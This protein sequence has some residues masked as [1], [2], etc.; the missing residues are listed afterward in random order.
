MKKST[1][2]RKHSA[3]TSKSKHLQR[4]RRN[5]VPNAPMKDSP[6]KG[7][8]KRQSGRK[9]VG[10]TRPLSQRMLDM[11]RANITLAVGNLA[12]NQA[13]I[14]LLTLT[15]GHEAMF[16]LRD[17][18]WVRFSGLNLSARLGFEMLMKQENVRDLLKLR[19][20]E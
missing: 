3:G 19:F 5:K 15:R 8:I 7:I 11:V 14:E 12:D 6:P 18:D 13:A 2:T 4:A 16:A 10:S 17:E 1:S 20:R 9:K